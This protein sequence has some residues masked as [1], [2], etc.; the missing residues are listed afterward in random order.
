V[1]QFDA[2][3]S[4]FADLSG[5]SDRLR[6]LLFLI[7]KKLS[8]RRVLRRGV[9]ITLAVLMYISVRLLIGGGETVQQVYFEGSETDLSALNWP[10]FRTLVIGLMPFLMTF[11][12]YLWITFLQ[13]YYRS[14]RDVASLLESSDYQEFGSYIHAGVLA[15][16]G[17]FLS[18]LRSLLAVDIG[19]TSALFAL[20]GLSCTLIPVA[21]QFVTSIVC[22]IVIWRDNVPM[23]V[24]VSIFYALF[25]AMTIMKTVSL[26]AVV[27]RMK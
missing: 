15:D 3:V 16:D 12:H 5:P 18:V 21:V 8:Q 14:Y 17:S 6:I 24:G 2:D 23:A 9:F 19:L 11:M 27:K 7:E 10:W 25:F 13:M 26:F 1:S 20:G 22:S 4:E